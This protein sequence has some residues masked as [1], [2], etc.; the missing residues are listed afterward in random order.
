MKVMTRLQHSPNAEVRELQFQKEMI[1]IKEKKGGSRIFRRLS[2]TNRIGELLLLGLALFHSPPPCSN[3]CPFITLYLPSATFNPAAGDIE[4]I[5]SIKEGK[6]GRRKSVDF[7][8][9]NYGR[10]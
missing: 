3:P 7:N 9:I 4:R 8:K 1:S 5:H 10:R 6:S 2:S